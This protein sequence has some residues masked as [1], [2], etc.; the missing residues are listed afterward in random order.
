MTQTFA[1]NENNDIYIGTDGNLVINS[2]IN[3]VRDACSNAA[4]AQKGEMVLNTQA[5][6]PNFQAVWTGNPDIA[7]FEAALQA[8]LLAVDGVFQILS[9]VT[10]QKGNNLVYTVSLLTVYGQTFL[11]GFLNGIS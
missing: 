1:V 5:G 6:I 8:A 10:Q 4:K 7:Q 3:A 2:G 9:M 11:T